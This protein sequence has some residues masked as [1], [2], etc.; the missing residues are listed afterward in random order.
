LISAS[1]TETAED[2]ILRQG[3]IRPDVAAR[4]LKIG[5]K[6]GAK[7]SAGQYRRSHC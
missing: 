7:R 1:A 4:Q 3:L 5:G 2:E 6:R